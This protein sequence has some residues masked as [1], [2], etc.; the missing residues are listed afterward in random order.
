MCL[1]NNADPRSQSCI[2]AVMLGSRPSDLAIVVQ[3]HNQLQYQL[4]ESCTQL[5]DR[6]LEHAHA[7]SL[8]TYVV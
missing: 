1:H 7:A 8:C 6:I 3:W 2:L 5:T 4:H